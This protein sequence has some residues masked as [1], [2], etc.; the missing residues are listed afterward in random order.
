[1]LLSGA[2]DDLESEAA[3]FTHLYDV[4]RQRAAS[5]PD[6]IALGS[7]QGL[8]WKM[9]DSR[10]LLDL[11][12]RLADELAQRGVREGD[13]VITW[14]PSSW[15]TPIYLFACWKLGAIVVPFDREMNQD[16]AAR[17][18]ER[19]EPSLIVVDGQEPPAW[20]PDEITVTWWEPGTQGGKAGGT[21]TQPAEDL[22]AIFFTLGSDGAPA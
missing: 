4:I 5:W 17:I 18:V 19:V 12:D 6:A 2:H 8:I 21:W 22:A 9:V 3:M 16:A 13:R 14:L 1:M 15:Q 10:Q 7:Q 20:A 11:T